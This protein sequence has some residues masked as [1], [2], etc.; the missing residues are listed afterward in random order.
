MKWVVQGRFLWHLQTGQHFVLF[1]MVQPV[2]YHAVRRPSFLQGSL[3]VHLLSAPASSIT[4]SWHGVC[5]RCFQPKCRSTDALAS[6]HDIAC[7]ILLQAEQDKELI[8][9]ILQYGEQMITYVNHQ[10]IKIYIHTALMLCNL[11]SPITEDDTLLVSGNR[12]L[13]SSKRLGKIAY[14]RASYLVFLIKS[15]S[16]SLSSFLLLLLLWPNSPVSELGLLFQVSR[17]VISYG[18]R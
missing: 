5:T 8:T 2:Y 11:G 3:K 7:F 15:S 9:T 16:L 6:Q 17:H 18:Q 4:E 10:S 1:W 12:V 14:W 13:K